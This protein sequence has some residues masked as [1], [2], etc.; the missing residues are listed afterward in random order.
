MERLRRTVVQLEEAKRFILNGE[1]ARLRLAVILLDNAVEVILHRRV[2]DTLRSAN[3]YARM[4]QQFPDGQLDAK[5]EALRQE[6][7]A[8]TIPQTR[9]KKVARFFGEKLALLSEHG[10]L[11]TATARALRHLHAYRNELQHQ[12]HVRPESIRPAALILFDIAVDLMVTLVPGSM[13]FGS[14]DN[15]DWLNDYRIEPIPFGRDDLREVIG[16]QLRHGLPLDVD[17]VRAALI[18]HLGTRLDAMEANSAELAGYG[19]SPKDLAGMLQHHRRW[20]QGLP[21]APSD[22]ADIAPFDKLDSLVRWRSDVASLTSIDDKL[23]LFD[24]FGT[25]ED[26][27]EPLERGLQE[28]VDAIGAAGEIASDIAR[29]A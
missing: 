20:E 17:G 24:R 15:I 26:E 13:S 14:D 28:V 10:E 16:T 3:A 1:V 19:L 27:L 21:D 12:D 6:I 7:A 22:A 2:N 9:Q 11:P 18:A 5:G 23:D 25:L 8:K 29:G 4:L